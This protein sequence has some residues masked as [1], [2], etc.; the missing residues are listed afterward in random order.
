MI[1]EA[2]STFRGDVAEGQTELRLELPVDAHIPDDYVDSERLRL[3]AYQKLSTASSPTSNDEQIDLV[4]EELTDR[5]GQPPEQVANLV[6]VSRLRRQAQKSGLGEVV[7]MGSNL[8]LAPADLPDSIQVRM[9]RM[10]PDAKYFAQAGAVS[11]PL[12]VVDGAVLED[13]ALI[14]WTKSV[15]TAL[16][17]A[18][19]LA[20]SEKQS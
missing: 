14:E 4:I 10:Y 19:V 1:G 17:P 20:E 7:T 3:E 16:F 5:Y 11:I 2:V 13:A 9:R 18:P 12:P 6:A 8:R 15:L